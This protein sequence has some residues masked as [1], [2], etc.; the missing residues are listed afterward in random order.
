MAKYYVY[1]SDAKANM[2][3]EQMSSVISF[4]KETRFSAKFGLWSSTE[5][6]GEHS[7]QSA[8][9]VNRYNKVDAIETA[10]K[11]D[12]AVGSL[13]SDKAYISGTS[14]FGWETTDKI[15]MWGTRLYVREKDELFVVILFGSPHNVVGN[16]YEGEYRTH[17]IYPY[18]LEFA[19]SALI[20]ANEEEDG[21][22]EDLGQEDISSMK[23]I[24]YMPETWELMEGMTYHYTG[25]EHEFQFLAKV[26]YR[27]SYTDEYRQANKSFVPGLYHAKKTTYVL[28]TPLY[29]VLS[30]SHNDR[31]ERIDN[32]NYLKANITALKRRYR[33]PASYEEL[34]NTVISELK[35]VGLRNEAQQLI[36]RIKESLVDA[37]SDKE[38]M[39]IVWQLLEE[40]VIDNRN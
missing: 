30:D 6:G 27:E 11:E 14:V 21:Y 38:A 35:N 25:Y 32:K 12:G 8:S 19:K 3:Y 22:I 15:S 26:L 23:T 17:S 40:Y 29:V 37:P 24:G 13:F 20:K 1:L 28:A 2:L 34:A 16:H 9:I 5:A 18:F 7:S 31:I 4:E 33:R 10:L 36:S 39:C